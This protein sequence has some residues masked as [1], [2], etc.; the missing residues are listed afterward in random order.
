MQV[1]VE[2][3]F[4]VHVRNVGEVDSFPAVFFLFQLKDV[5]IEKEL[6]L[7]VGEVDAELLEAIVNEVLEPKNIE[8]T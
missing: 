1:H 2:Q 5:L 4:V 8:N 6:Q 3:R 7:F